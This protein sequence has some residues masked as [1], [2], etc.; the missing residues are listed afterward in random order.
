MEGI[1]LP[2]GHLK[3][4][5]ALCNVHTSVLIVSVSCML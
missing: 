5:A 4:S 3:T 2:H 1:S